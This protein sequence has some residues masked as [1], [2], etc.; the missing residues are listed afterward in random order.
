MGTNKLA[1]GISTRGEK[2]AGGI[3]IQREKSRRVDR[4]EQGKGGDSVDVMEG[5]R[6]KREQKIRDM[7]LSF[8]R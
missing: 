3:M 4:S 7:Q 2:G 6:D 8:S 5:G 1:S